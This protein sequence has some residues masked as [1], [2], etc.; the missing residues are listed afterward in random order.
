MENKDM[1]E[2][3]PEEMDDEMGE[4]VED[5]DQDLGDSRERIEAILALTAAGAAPTREEEEEFFSVIEELKSRNPGEDIYYSY[6]PHNGFF[7]YRREYMSDM[8]SIEEKVSDLARTLTTRFRQK[9]EKTISDIRIA[10][11]KE[12]VLA[13]S[14]KEKIEPSGVH[15][16][17][18]LIIQRLPKEAVKEYEDIDGKV[19][20]LAILSILEECVL[21][22]FDMKERIASRRIAIGVP[23][24]LSSYIH[25]I[26]G[27]V[28]NVK[29][30]KG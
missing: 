22:P 9:Y 21:Y 7:A 15:V 13:N 12:Y 17:E 27:Y 11:Q 23:N 18:E 3:I 26:S 1:T 16:P 20:D 24:I 6:I 10:I 29:I 28:K 14:G 5:I 2:G 30:R 19:E 8:A 25:Q 4:N